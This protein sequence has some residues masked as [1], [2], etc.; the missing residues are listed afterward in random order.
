[1]LGDLF[2][3]MMETPMLMIIFIVDLFL[4]FTILFYVLNKIYKKKRPDQSLLAFFN[5][6]KLKTTKGHVKDV[7]TL[8][9]F[10]VNAYAG[11]ISVPRGEKGYKAR[12]AI[13]KYIKARR[14]P[15]EYEVVKAIFDGY[16]MKKYGG[17][18]YNEGS[19]V[20]SLFSRFRAL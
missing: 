19:V 5:R 17:G 16:E 20:N 15:A 2:A 12:K 13:L 8:Y 18:V 14:K 7:E 10:V 4:I 11:R 9:D 6:F 3:V 1:M